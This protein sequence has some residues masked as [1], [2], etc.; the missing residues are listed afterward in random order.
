MMMPSVS[1]PQR[2]ASQTHIGLTLQ[3]PLPLPQL[4]VSETEQNLDP[5][6]WNV[7]TGICG[8]PEKTL[9]P[10]VGEMEDKGSPLGVDE[11]DSFF[12]SA[13]VRRV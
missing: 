9:E 6:S 11:Q 3:L 7:G 2:I 13:S 12:S 4:R 8:S 1:L 5:S 10:G